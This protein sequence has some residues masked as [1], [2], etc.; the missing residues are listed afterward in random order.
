MVRQVTGRRQIRRPAVLVAA[1]AGHRRHLGEHRPELRVVLD[2]EGELEQSQD[3]LGA[4]EMIGHVE[5]VESG[6]RISGQMIGTRF[7]ID[8]G[9][10]PFDIGHLPKPGQNAADGQIRGQRQPVRPMGHGVHLW[11][12]S[13]R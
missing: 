8:Q 10:G 11:E 5:A 6:R 2:I 9:T 12:E 13:D 4:A 3:D 7:G 1:I